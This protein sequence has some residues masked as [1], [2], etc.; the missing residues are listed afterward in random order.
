MYNFYFWTCT[1]VY[2]GGNIAWVQA[3]NKP[4]PPVAKEIPCY[5]ATVKTLQSMHVTPNGELTTVPATYNPPTC[6]A[7]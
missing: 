1:L 5:I 4:I 6:K 7:P 3:T 2:V